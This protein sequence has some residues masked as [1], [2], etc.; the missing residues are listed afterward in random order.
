MKRKFDD[1]DSLLIWL[2]LFIDRQYNQTELPLYSLRLSN[3][4]IPLFTDSELFTCAI[5]TE[6]MKCR[7]KKDGYLYLRRHYLTWFPNLPKYE[8]YIRKLNKYHEAISY[9]FKLL[10]NTFAVLS[11]QKIAQ[12]D[13]APVSVSQ[14]QH[15]SRARAAKPFVS[16]GYCPSKRMYYV[17]VKLQVISQNRV[18]QLPYPIDY[19]IETAEMHDLDIAKLTL[20]YS[21]LSDIDLYGDKGY[22]DKDFQL[23]L[24]DEKH[25]NLI[26]PNKKVKG[27]PPLTLFQNAYNAIHSSIRQ[28]IDTL[29]G[30]IDDQTNIEN[31]SKVRSVDG[32][33]Y[34]INIKM[35]V[36]L[37]LL[38]IQF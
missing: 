30:W 14:A 21:E 24:F 4:C 9:I 2:Y 3:N 33:F 1:I 7:T 11:D 10:R 5:F 18:S 19:H 17:G 26:T 20:P 23:D 16:K 34:H 22:I 32:L 38:V 8:V 15:S 31:A 13:T 36:A 12:I 6:L 25:I 29:L 35:V 28:P 37:L 27:Q